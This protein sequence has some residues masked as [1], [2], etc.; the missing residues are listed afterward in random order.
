MASASAKQIGGALSNRFQDGSRVPFVQVLVSPRPP[1]FDI[2]SPDAVHPAQWPDALPANHV[3]TILG[4]LSAALV[5]ALGTL[6]R[7]L[8]HRRLALEH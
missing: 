2:N 5:R 3:T 1:P 7:R 6:A 4:A 8:A